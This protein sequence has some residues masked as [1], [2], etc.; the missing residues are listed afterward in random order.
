MWGHMLTCWVWPS[1]LI[2]FVGD[3]P[4]S[5]PSVTKGVVWPHQGSE[6]GPLHRPARGRTVGSRIFLQDPWPVANLRL[7]SACLLLW[8]SCGLQTCLAVHICL[9]ARVLCNVWVAKFCRRPNA[10]QVK[11]IAI[12]CAC[13]TYYLSVLSIVVLVTWLFRMRCFEFFSMK[14]PSCSWQ[15]LRCCK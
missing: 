9:S 3:S 1:S 13:V 15:L 4:A 7:Y 10:R 2:L 8:I 11:R 12:E 5:S 14:V 6:L